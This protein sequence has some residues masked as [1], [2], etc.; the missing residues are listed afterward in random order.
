M[1][2][3]ITIP[4]TIFAHE[5]VGTVGKA[6]AVCGANIGNLITNEFAQNRADYDVDI[7]ITMKEH[8]DED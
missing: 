6:M 4:L 8:E 2:K 3:G 5:K 1:T 7:T